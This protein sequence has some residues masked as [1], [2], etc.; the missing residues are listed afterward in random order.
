MAL[1]TP[2]YRDGDSF[3]PWKNLSPGG[4]GASSKSTPT[5]WMGGPKMCCPC[6]A[7]LIKPGMVS[8]SSTMP[9]PS[10]TFAMVAFRAFKSQRPRCLK[11]YSLTSSSAIKW[12]S[13][14]SMMRKGRECHQSGSG[15]FLT[16]TVIADLIE[17]EFVLFIR[18]HLLAGVPDSDD[19][20]D[21]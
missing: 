20:M 15:L 4:S 18:D 17:T 2:A 7:S 13:G 21:G 6:P 14:P 9:I 1:T 19:T 8:S 3:S 10:R 12:G 5:P 16:V 11:T